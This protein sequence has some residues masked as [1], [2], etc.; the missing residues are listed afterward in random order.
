MPERRIYYSEEAKQ[1]AQQR[2]MLQIGLAAVIGLT[3]GVM[4]ALLF[5]PQSGK[6]LRQRIAGALDEG[7]A[8]GREATDDAIAQLE[9]EF[10]GIQKRIAEMT[11]KAA[12][13]AKKAL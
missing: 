3:F 13:R 6:K 7:Y 10:P 12:Q 9:K 2:Q 5:A 11:K 8:R 4:V 1:Y